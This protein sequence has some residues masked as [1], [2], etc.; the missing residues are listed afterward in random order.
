MSAKI[1]EIK[2]MGKENGKDRK[3]VVVRIKDRKGN[4]KMIKKK[5]H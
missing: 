4:M 2:E 5:L 1:K 3:I